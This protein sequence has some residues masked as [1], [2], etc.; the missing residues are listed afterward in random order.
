M[1]NLTGNI[2]L[3]SSG[4]QYALFIVFTTAVFFFIDRTGRRP[5]LLY[6]AMGMGICHFIVGGILGTYSTLVPGGVDGNLN[7]I[8]R[9][10]GSP[11]YTVI[12]FS[13][14]LIIIYALTLGKCVPPLE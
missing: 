9:V 8:I 7:V 5:L 3:V 6:G 14:M 10:S 1:A 12:A 11:A 4:V 13:Y 2:L